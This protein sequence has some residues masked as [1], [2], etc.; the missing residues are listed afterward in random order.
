[1]KIINRVP[2]WSGL[3]LI[4]SI[5][6]ISIATISPFNFQIPTEFSEHTIWSEFE[7]TSSV[8]DYWQNILLFVPLGISLAAFFTGKK[9]SIPTSFAFACLF[10]ILTSSVVEITQ[11]FWLVVFLMWLI[12]SV[13]AWEGLSGQLFTFGASRLLSSWLGLFKGILS[14]W[15]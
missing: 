4:A 3:L 5:T 2:R 15:V 8:K 10:S 1:M 11:L 14:A 6:A 13:T 9:L 12:L 7:F